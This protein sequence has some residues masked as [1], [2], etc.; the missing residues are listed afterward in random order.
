[1]NSMRKKRQKLVIQKKHKHLHV[2]DDLQL[3][4]P[5]VTIKIHNKQKVFKSSP[6][7]FAMIVTTE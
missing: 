3:D 4:F 2:C 7:P 5:K 1:M 6:W